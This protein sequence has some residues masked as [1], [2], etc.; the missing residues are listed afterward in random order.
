MTRSGAGWTGLGFVADDLVK[1]MLLT[2]IRFIR[3]VHNTL[4]L[5]H[6]MDAM[7]IAGSPASCTSCTLEPSEPRYAS[8]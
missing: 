4:I 8:A 3:I 2:I 6:H 5:V 1:L 7:R